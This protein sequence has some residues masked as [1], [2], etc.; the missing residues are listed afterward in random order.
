MQLV[1]GALQ[2]I[3]LAVVELDSEINQPECEILI[4]SQEAIICLPL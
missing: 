2:V 3:K 1:G 4:T